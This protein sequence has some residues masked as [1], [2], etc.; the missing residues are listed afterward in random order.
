M[1][2]KEVVS[3]CGLGPQRVWVQQLLNGWETASR[4]LLKRPI[5]D[6]PLMI[7]FDERCSWSL[8][9]VDAGERGDTS[10][11]RY[12]GRSVRA[13]GR[14]HGDSVSIPGGRTI[15]VGPTSFTTVLDGTKVP[16]FVVALP[17]VWRNSPAGAGD[18]RID[19]F[20]LAVAMHELAHTLQIPAALAR[21]DSLR[22][23]GVALPEDLSDDLIE[24][25]FAKDTAFVRMFTAER[26]LY[27]E[28]A[29]ATEVADTRRFA[30]QAL[31]ITRQRQARFFVGRYAGFETAEDV[32]VSLEGVG[33]WV[34]YAMARKFPD[35]FAI[36]ERTIERRG[37]NTDW[38]QG[39]S[40]AVM[41]TLNRLT[42]EWQPA[43]LGRELAS[44]FALLEQALGKDK[45][46][47][48]S[49]T[50]N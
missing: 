39:E 21:I 24:N 12:A 4:D 10:S 13:I 18:R 19:Q 20:V 32:F 33:T 34:S 43:A 6:L 3:G 41:I 36:N 47:F 46:R 44:P 14:M 37:R 7:L 5:D 11:L 45:K 29:F 16:F 40:M 25:T 42:T 49:E 28:A 30:R 31:A 1:Q 17:S 2:K 38:V 35:L 22:N 50:G 23:A 48:N 26:A 8:E 27:F 9:H 15:P